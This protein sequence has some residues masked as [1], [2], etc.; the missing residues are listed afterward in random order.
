MRFKMKGSSFYG[1]GS[2][3]VTNNPKIMKHGADGGSSPE[4]PS[5]QK[6]KKSEE[7]P[8]VIV[9]ERFRSPEDNGGGVPNEGGFDINSKKAKNKRNWKAEPEKNLP[10]DNIVDKKIVKKKNTPKKTKKPIKKVV[11]KKEDATTGEKILRG[12]L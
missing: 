4:Q 3:K 1:K 5:K 8:K 9:I 12:D 7:A 10:N 11:S 2:S 6:I